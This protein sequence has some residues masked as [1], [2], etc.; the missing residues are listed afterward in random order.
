MTFGQHLGADEYLCFARRC[1][2][3]RFDHRAFESR[4]VTVD[5]T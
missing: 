1:H 4:A 5:A 2:R 3:E